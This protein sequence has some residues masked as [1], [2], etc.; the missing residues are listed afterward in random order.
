MEY[1]DYIEESD[2]LCAECG[3]PYDKEYCSKKCYINSFKQKIMKTREELKAKIEKLQYKLDNFKGLEVGKWYK[4]EQNLIFCFNGTY[5]N[6][7]QYGFDHLENWKDKIGCHEHEDN[8]VLATNLEVETALIKEAKKRGFKKGV[9]IN[10]LSEYTPKTTIEGNVKWYSNILCDG[11]GYGGVIFKDGVWA[12]IIE[13]PKTDYE[14]ITFP[15]GFKIT[16]E[17]LEEIKKYI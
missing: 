7:T 12:E 13:E 11:G 2:N 1:S 9:R 6:S 16:T 4:L 14:F 3:T 10:G 8:Y 17:H 15:S 5:G